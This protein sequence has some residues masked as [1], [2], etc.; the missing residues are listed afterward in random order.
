M[1]ALPTRL[2]ALAG[3]LL[4]GVTATTAVAAGAAQAAVT[5]APDPYEVDDSFQ[6]AAP[7]AVGATAYRAICQGREVLPGKRFAQ[8][9]DYFV[10]TAAEGQAYTVTAVDLGAQVGGLE[11]WISRVG[12]DNQTVSIDY[13]RSPDGKRFTT[14][15][16]TAG[17]YR[18]LALTNEQEI[19]PEDNVITLKTVQGDAGRYGVRLAATAPAPVLSA[20]T[21]SPGTV[22]GGKGATATLTFTGPVLAGGTWFY[23]SSNNGF[24]ANPNGSYFVPEG[25]TRAT[26]PIETHR[27]SGDTRVTFTGQMSFIGPKIDAVLTVRK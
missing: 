23:L 18:I 17:Q 25:A 20:L 13:N 8:D 2:L 15:P 1:T 6:T 11:V 7:V 4:A 21:I 16:L 27:P 22:S 3:A 9:N 14:G 24:I 12:A 10:F 19:Y 5:C 26:M